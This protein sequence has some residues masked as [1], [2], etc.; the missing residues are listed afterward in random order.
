MK[1]TLA[2][3]AFAALVGAA[4]AQ[5]YNAFKDVTFSDV[6]VTQTGNSFT[7]SLGSDPTVSR[8]VGNG[9][10]KTS[11]I[12]NI[13]GFW[14][15]SSTGDIMANQQS[16][17]NW[18]MRT[19]TGGGT[20]AYGWNA[21]QKNGL[22]ANHSMTFTFNGFTGSQVT[23]YGFSLHAKGTPDHVKTPFKGQPVPE[24]LSLAALAIGAGAL[25]LRKRSK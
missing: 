24:P 25:F 5:N 3:F 23:D 7:V 12:D 15:L 19:N 9:H 2:I 17:T 20:S 10:V 13:T 1:R 16:A 21:Q 14:L 4:S 22:T 6:T 8:T 11:S 18:Q